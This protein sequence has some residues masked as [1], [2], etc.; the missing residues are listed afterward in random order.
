LYLG[1]PKALVTG[2]GYHYQRFCELNDFGGE[3]QDSVTA[4]GDAESV[5]SVQILPWSQ[6]S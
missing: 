4:E 6:Y 1:Q 3:Y 2:K 5:E